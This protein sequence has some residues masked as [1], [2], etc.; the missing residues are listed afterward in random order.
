L[1]SGDY[2]RK[3][4]Q[5]NLSLSKKKKKK[6]KKKKKKKKKK[7]TKKKENKNLSQDLYISELVAVVPESYKR[8]RKK[9]GRDRG[10]C[11]RFESEL[12]KAVRLVFNCSRRGEILPLGMS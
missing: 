12:F 3:K 5:G 9:W 1:E 10:K 6:E 4:I 2:G 11:G 7:K 8:G